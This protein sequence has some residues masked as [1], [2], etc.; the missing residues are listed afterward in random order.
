[1]Q[2]FLAIERANEV[3]QMQ[4]IQLAISQKDNKEKV[5]SKLSLHNIL[6]TV[7]CSRL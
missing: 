1:M 3:S 5:S 7:A 4:E 6:K 2:E